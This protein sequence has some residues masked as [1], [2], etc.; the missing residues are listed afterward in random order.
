[1]PENWI[2][3]VAVPNKVQPTAGLGKGKVVLQRASLPRIVTDFP[4]QRVGGRTRLMGANLDDPQKPLPPS[5][6]LNRKS[7]VLEQN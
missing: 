2:P 5:S 1:M 3:L 6:F 7:R 4:V